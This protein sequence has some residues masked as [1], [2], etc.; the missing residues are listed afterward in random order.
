MRRVVLAG[1]VVLA[2]SAACA[3]CNKTSRSGDVAA[4]HTT[5]QRAPSREELVEVVYDGGLK[6]GWQDW[7][8]SKRDSQGPGPA[9]VHFANWGGFILAKMDLKSEGLGALVF[10]VKEPRGEGEFLEVRVESGSQTTF[11]RVKIG[12]EHRAEIADGWFEVKVPMWELNP[13]GSPWDRV[14]IRAF[15][16]VSE[17]VTLLDGIGFTKGDPDSGAA[18]RLDPTAYSSEHT[19]KVSAKVMCG[20]RATKISPYIY[21]IAYG[22]DAK[23]QFE[24]GATI[25]R[26]GG[27]NTARYNFELETW[28]LNFNWFFENTKAPSW[29]QFLDDDAAHK[30]KSAITL[31]TLG[32]VAKDDKSMTFPVSQFG[33][34]EKT[35][36]YKP[37]AGN[38][39]KPGGDK[40]TPPSPTQTSI[41][42]PPEWDAKWVNAI[43]A[44]DAAAKRQHQVQIYF[45]D[46]EPMIWQSTHRDVRTEPL[47]YD[48]L[49]EKT[50][51]YGSAV[52]KADP[53][54]M[55]AGPSDWGWPA[56]FYSGK[57]AVAGFMRKPDR[58]AHGD[59]PLID[60]YLQKLKEHQDKTGERVLDIL[61]LHYYPQGEGI[62][63]GG[64]SKTDKETSKK[65]LRSTRSWWDPGYTDE[66]WVKDQVRL[67]PRMQEWVAKNYPGTKI[68]I[69]EWNFGAEKHISGGLAIAESLGRFAQFGLYSAFYWQF[70]AGG[71]PGQQAY[72]AYR[73]FDGKGGRFQDWYVPSE[74]PE[75]TSLFV[76]RDEA[77]THAVA[78]ILNMSPDD[79]VL[80]AL[81]MNGC[82]PVTS[83]RTYTYVAGVKGLQ[84]AP[85]VTAPGP[86]EQFLPPWSIVVIDMTLGAPMSGAVE[87]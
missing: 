1:L 10:R 32:W 3:A 9:Q 55:I 81:D 24:V 57:D 76:S 71:S 14:I 67:L 28:N 68:S 5:A 66:S 62:F 12:A 63:E 21:G 40:V 30:M 85:P 39:I 16:T 61:D 73:N 49:L 17:E 42:A 15:R 44:A 2:A 83:R 13:D 29:K 36:P 70:P 35:D 11:P 8:W 27:D 48:E 87:K 74:A 50:I 4:S 34:Q 38:G 86:V 22:G 37:E 82:A 60:W 77:G 46:N 56:Y 23:D 19:K 69:G 45:L 51:N 64:N 47:G 31:P 26:W 72:L 52:R 7:G 18:S 41:A 78:V 65:R 79:A 80:E 59:V 53:T 54:A 25:R 84:P 20:A 75:G 33:P 58:R 6:N 43:N